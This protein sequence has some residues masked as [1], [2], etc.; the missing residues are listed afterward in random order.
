MRT[1]ALLAI[2]T[3]AITSCATNNT[4]TTTN[5]TPTNNPI[6]R[7]RVVCNPID[8]K[9][10]FHRL[11]P[12]EDAS[13]ASGAREAADPICLIY[14]DTYYLFPSKCEGYFSS[15]D[16]QHWTH[17]ST[18][19]LPI[20]LYAPAGMI[21]DGELYWAASGGRV[22]Y[23][24]KTPE[25]GNSWTLVN[26]NFIPDPDSPR[27]A[28]DPELFVD[29]DGRVYLY[30]GC[31]NVEDIM[32]IELDPS[33]NF[34]PIGKPR[35]LITHMQQTYGWERR[36]D[37]NELEEPG[38]NEGATMFKHNGRYYLQYAS[39]GTQFET[40]GDGVYVGDQPLGPFRHQ[41]SSPMSIKQGG[42][43][44]GAGHG[45]TF[46]DK[47]GNI[48][49]VA[50]TVISQRLRFE[51]RI[52]FFPTFFTETGN[53]Y[54]LTDLSDSPYV[55]P[56][57]EV[58]FQN[59]APWTGWRI[60]SEGK[61]ATASSELADHP[62]TA[63]ADNKIKT[64]WSAQ[65]GTE[66]EWLTIDLGQKDLVHAVQTNFADH[67]FGFFDKATPKSPY[68]YTI[69][70]STNGTRW[71]LLADKTSNDTDNPH[72][73]IVP[74]K[75]V[76]A[77]Y[78]RITNKTNLDGKFSIFDLR[79]F[80]IAPGAA[81]AP[82]SGLAATRSAD[83]RTI[84]FTWSPTPDATGYILR[85]GTDPDE[86]Y[87]AIELPASDLTRNNNSNSTTLSTTLGLFT[88]DQTYYF[89]LDTYNESGLTR[90]RQ[91]IKLEKP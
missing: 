69:E 30:S 2:I 54:A 60:L 21:Y 66:G 41:P 29:D 77:R 49:H 70:Y 31:S 14:N 91:T 20:T 26:D 75:P 51:R 68:K 52:A 42:W 76:K 19:V 65:T 84:T 17:I 37:N 72:E 8:I 5:N 1:T 32:G 27:A 44:T 6:D 83:P 23:K 81:P 57:K 58:D 18:D 47:H 59:E 78:I 45:Y 90:S 22:L 3:L 16:M 35:T 7:T 10:A 82:A 63:A 67:D 50:S 53:M 13:E 33:N 89:T 79:V 11:S 38:Y 86:L 55:L 46:K 9:Y 61:K 71:H 39:P 56:D 28:N 43:M 36:G 4:N 24:T 80:G 34:T 12:S 48:W 88:T 40:Y 62:A 74:T 64:Y 87:S 25:D 73:L 15:D 85:W